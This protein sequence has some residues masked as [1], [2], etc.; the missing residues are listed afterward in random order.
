M[1]KLSFVLLALISSSA[2]A[3]RIPTGKWQQ[4]DTNAGE[5]KT[6]QITVG[7]ITPD[8]LEVSGNNG[9]AGYIY[10]DKSEDRYSGV[11]QWRNDKVIYFIN[12]TYHNNDLRLTLQ[13]ESS[14]YK[15]FVTYE[16]I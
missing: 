9:W 6:C 15:Y 16:K 3:D 13:A 10:Y 12:M 2:I 7:G 1:K 4:I 14:P 5:C 8:I 11:M